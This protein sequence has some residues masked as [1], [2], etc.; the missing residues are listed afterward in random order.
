[1]SGHRVESMSGELPFLN[2]LVLV[3]PPLR[4]YLGLPKKEKPK[5]LHAASV[6]VSGADENFW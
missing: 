6:N 4:S 5:E 3:W 2:L 1:M